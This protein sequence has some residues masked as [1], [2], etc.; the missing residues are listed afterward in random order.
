MERKDAVIAGGKPMT[1]I[2]PEL[3]AGDK[4]PD[5]TC[6]DAKLNPV[7][8]SGTSG[9]IRL[10]ATVPSLD[11][12]VCSLE[13]ARFNKEAEELPADKV[14][15]I[16]ISVDLPFAQDRFCSMEGIKNVKVLSDYR[17][18]AMGQSYGVLIKETRLL[19]RAVFV[20]DGG[21]V[22]RYVEY[23]PELGQHP[24]Y[25]AALNAVRGLVESKR[26]AA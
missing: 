19:S 7:K 25:D 17:D 10:I 2:G 1:L 16:V 9:K 8:L 14:A 15:V 11:T 13:T 3:K 20:V 22:V 24:D 21:D 5:F 6:L 12:K 26:A 18:V 23:V 4:A